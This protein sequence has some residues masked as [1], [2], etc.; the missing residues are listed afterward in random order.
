SGEWSPTDDFRLRGSF[1]RAVRAPNVNELFLPNAVSANSGKDP[2]SDLNGTAV[3]YTT[4]AALCLATGVPNAQLFN[5]GL[6]CPAGQCTAFD[7]GKANL[8]PEVANTRSAGIVF[9]PTFFD[10]FSATIDYYNIKVDGF[11]TGLP[12]QLV[13]NNCYDPA[14]NPTQ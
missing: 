7:G 4:T 5:S 14:K 13:L 1:E 11:I 3:G 8:K 10:G 12:L 9:T 6:E 2:C